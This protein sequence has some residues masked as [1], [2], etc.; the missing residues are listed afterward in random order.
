MT[1]E[2]GFSEDIGSRAS[3]FMCPVVSSMLIS[4]PSSIELEIAY[5]LFFDVAKAK[6][7]YIKNTFTS[8]MFDNI[9]LLN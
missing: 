8:N 2:M 6:M 7:Y 5:M 4:R 9:E 1:V 3:C